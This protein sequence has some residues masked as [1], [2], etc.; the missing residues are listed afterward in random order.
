MSLQDY[1]KTDDCSVTEEGPK[2]KKQKKVPAED[3]VEFQLLRDKAKAM[4]SCPEEWKYVSKKKINVLREWII[5]HEFIRDKQTQSS[6]SAGAAGVFTG[7]L[8]W[9]MGGKGH[10]SSELME[11]QA[12]RDSFD[13]E[14]SGWTK[15]LSNKARLAVL[16]STGCVNGKQSQLL[17]SPGVPDEII[18]EV[19]QEINGELLQGSVAIEQSIVH[20]D[21]HNQEVVN[22]EADET[23]SPGDNP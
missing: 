10:V 1:I 15:F 12:W 2:K 22:E 9:S 13:E 3:N 18:E 19:Q 4:C 20:G 8:D 5:E 23:V 7:I 17:L 21:E 6:I 16:T 14:V 11:N